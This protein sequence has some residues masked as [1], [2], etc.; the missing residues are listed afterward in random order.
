VFLTPRYPCL[1]NYS[2]LNLS[3]TAAAEAAP[4]RRPKKIPIVP[5]PGSIARKKDVP[6]SPWKMNFL[7]K[8]VRRI[9]Y[10]YLWVKLLFIIYKINDLKRRN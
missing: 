10:I 1:H 2:R 9:I 6:Q 4:L 8:L 7:V 5:Q 3:S